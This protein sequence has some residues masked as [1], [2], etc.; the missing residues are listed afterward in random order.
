MCRRLVCLFAPFHA[1]PQD[2][3]AS[4]T[5]FSGFD[6]GSSTNFTEYN[7]DTV[8][9]LANDF[10]GQCHCPVRPLASLHLLLLLE[11]TLGVS[12]RHRP[13]AASCRRCARLG[14]T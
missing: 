2:P 8:V 4:T 6:D 5:S 12:P 10:G 11:L 9:E 1:H 14:W 3:S 13:A 7:T